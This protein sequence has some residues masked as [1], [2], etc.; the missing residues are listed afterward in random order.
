M[1]METEVAQNAVA[2]SKSMARLSEKEKEKT[3]LRERQ[4]RA[5]TTKIFSGLRKHGGYNLPPRADINDVLKALVR[6]AGWIVEPDGTTYRSQLSGAIALQ[7]SPR[8]VAGSSGR[9]SLTISS[10]SM[11]GFPCTMPAIFTD[12]MDSRTGDCSTTASPRHTGAISNSNS[13]SMSLLHSNSNLSSPFA[14]P[15]SSEGGVPMTKTANPFLAGIPSGFQPCTQAS[16][17]FGDG[18]AFGIR[19]DD[20]ISFYANNDTFDSRDLGASNLDSMP[21]LLYNN[22]PQ[23]GQARRGSLQIPPL[24]IVSQQYPFWQ[25]SR[26]SN[27]NTPIGSPQPHRSIM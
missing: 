4:R 27:E 9:A 6:E 22:I 24:M 2:S 12:Y 5:I 13:T 20:F 23:Q 3:K 18:D 21:N 17:D 14:S 11:G 25:E 7:P 26:A 1:K 8:Q 15:A 10:G 16:L 19:S